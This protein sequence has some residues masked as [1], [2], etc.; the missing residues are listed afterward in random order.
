M[1]FG[2]IS[3]SSCVTLEVAFLFVDAGHDLQRCGTRHGQEVRGALGFS[4]L[5]VLMLMLVLVLVFAPIIAKVPAS[6]CPWNL[7]AKGKQ[8]AS[9]NV[10]EAAGYSRSRRGELCFSIAASRQRG[11]TNDAT[12]SRG[13]FSASR[14]HGL[15]WLGFTRAARKT[16]P[17]FF[18]TSVVIKESSGVAPANSEPPPIVAAISRPVAIV[19]NARAF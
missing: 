5:L 14:R 11:C 3:I 6:C 18:D 4:S 15:M 17:N 12:L 1:V 16:G 13:P 2:V 7:R 10:G 8:R 19:R 9:K